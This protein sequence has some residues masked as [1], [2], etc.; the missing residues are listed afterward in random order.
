MKISVVQVWARYVSYDN[1][2]YDMLIKGGL[3]G[4]GGNSVFNKKFGTYS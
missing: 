4:G 2:Y 3:D 1:S